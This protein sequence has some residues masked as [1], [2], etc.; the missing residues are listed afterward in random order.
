M[1][2]ASSASPKLSCCQFANTRPAQAIQVLTDQHLLS[3]P[4]VDDDGPWAHSTGHRSSVEFPF[5]TDGQTMSSF[6][7]AY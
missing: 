7:M 2:F 4:V 3:A 5:E 6:T 1:M